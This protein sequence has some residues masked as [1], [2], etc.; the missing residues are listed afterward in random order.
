MSWLEEW[1]N[2][3]YEAIELTAQAERA[4]IE[5]EFAISMHKVEAFGNVG[6]SHSTNGKPSNAMP[7]ERGHQY[8][9]ADCGAEI[10]DSNK[11]DGWT[12][13]KKAQFSL[14]RHGKIVCYK[15]EQKLKVAA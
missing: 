2:R 13:D 10:K 5:A 15:C 7:D 1:K 9:C 8:K 11:P 6:K 12:A 14:D 3:S 4:K